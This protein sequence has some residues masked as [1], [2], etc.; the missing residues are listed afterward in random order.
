MS[1][2]IICTCTYRTSPP[3]GWS[4]RE[5]AACKLVRVLK[6]LPISG[7]AD[8]PVD[9]RTIRLDQSNAEE[10]FPLFARL[11]TPHIDWQHAPTL[12]VPIPNSC[13]VA[14]DAVPRT[15]CLADALV[16]H[17]GRVDLAVADVLRWREPM[18]AAHR[19]GAARYP[20][21]LYPNLRLVRTL[22]A[23]S[24]VLLVDDLLTTGGHL[25]AAAAFLGEAGAR[26]A[27]GVCAGR[28]DEHR[29]SDPFAARVEVLEP[30]VFDPS[31]F[32]RVDEAS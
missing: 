26:V 9:G 11:A 17:A 4:D 32:G 12:L 19:W 2:R 3:R 30:F 8:I 16:A 25:R 15:R 5:F 14:A 6:G 20:E 27:G 23:R 1:L 7:W 13:S 31:V 21:Q 18:P 29:V 24:V 10:A 22:P 28:A